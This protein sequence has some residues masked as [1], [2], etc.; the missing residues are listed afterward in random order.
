MNTIE[1][2]IKN[3]FASQHKG[4][5]IIDGLSDECRAYAIRNSEW[6]GVAIKNINNI[7]ISEEFSSCAIK[8]KY[9]S[10]GNKADN[11]LVLFCTDDMIRNKFATLSV[12]F[13]CSENRVQILADPFAWWQEWKQLL[14]NAISNK[15]VYDIIAEMMTLNE[16]FDKCEKVSW[17][18]ISRGTHDVETNRGDYEVK[19]TIKRFDN[20]VT[21]SSQFQLDK[22]KEL[23]LVFYRFEKSQ[24]GLCINDVVNSLVEKGYDP[25]KLENQL[26]KIGFEKGKSARKEK[27]KV[28]ASLQ[29]DVDDNFPLITKDSFKGNKI[30]DNVE[31]IVY[32]IS[33]NG[34]KNKRFIG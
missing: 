18:A 7:E 25:Y 22:K 34:I 21:I 32:T 29:Y 10:V 26:Q 1:T 27:Y 31:K 28:L 24:E 11:F 3:Y 20:T 5:S 12:D 6:Y 33:L 13:V 16:L 15:K 23:K 19:S 8:N 4:G 17:N 30:P 9:I 14:G 2:S